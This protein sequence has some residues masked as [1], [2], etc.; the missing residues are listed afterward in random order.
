MPFSDPIADGV[1]IQE[2]NTVNI[3]VVGMDMMLTSQTYKQVALR[4]NV[5][6]P[7]CLSQLKSAR[8]KGLTA[9]VLLMGMLDVCPQ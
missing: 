7:I 9:P 1:A 2:S 3:H 8:Q 4:N 6:Y 5:D